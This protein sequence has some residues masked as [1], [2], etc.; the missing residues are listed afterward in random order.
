MLSSLSDVGERAVV[1]G[2]LKLL[3]P[4]PKEALPIGDDASALSLGNGLALVVKADMLVA[5][6]DVPPGMSNQ[7]IGRKVVTM[8]FSDLAA[9][10]AKP[11]GIL[12]SLGLPRNFR[13]GEA[14]DIMR[15]LVSEAREYGACTM[16]GDTGEASD[17]VISCAVLGICQKRRL[18]KRSGAKPGDYVAVTGFFGKTA[19][20]LK[21]LMEK[22][23]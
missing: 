23:L 22:M 4:C 10:G 14:L 21:I 16:G 18:I 7:Q 20:G 9:M 6:T 17:L 2:I 15:G 1:E 5:S 11:T 12:V 8:N 3:S 13:V 19:S